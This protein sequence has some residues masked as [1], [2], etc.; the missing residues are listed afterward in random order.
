MY[1][2]KGFGEA[3]PFAY[4]ARIAEQVT[5]GDKKSQ[6]LFTK[7][8]REKDP[9]MNAAMANHMQSIYD[10]YASKKVQQ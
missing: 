7:L 9:Q 3:K 4:Y 10:N 5:K 2:N 6:K 8:M 1:K